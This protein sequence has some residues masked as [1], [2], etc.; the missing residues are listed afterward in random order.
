M[1]EELFKKLDNELQEYKK[2][3]KEKGVDFAVDKAYELTAKQEMIDSIMFD[4]NLSKTEIKALMSKENVLDELYQ[5]WLSF[6]G[7]MRE[8]I[9]YSIDESLNDIVMVEYGSYA[10][11]IERGYVGEECKKTKVLLSEEPDFRIIQT[12]DLMF[13]L[14]FKNAP[15]II[16]ATYNIYKGNC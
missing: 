2:F 11:F 10:D 12:E 6:D 13:L 8:H 7:N 1:E 16:P 9:S 14:K 5:D 3:V 15:S 4:R